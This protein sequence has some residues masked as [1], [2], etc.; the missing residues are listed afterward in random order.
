M[1]KASTKDAVA[2]M[3]PLGKL[4]PWEGNPRDNT[5]AV[6]AV[7]E[8]IARFGF[9]A[10]IVARKAD[11]EI[12]AGHTRWLAAQRLGMTE[13]PVRYL[14]LSLAEARALNLADN[15]VGEIAQWDEDKLLAA[16]AELHAEGA[17]LEGL[18]F[19]DFPQQV[20]RKI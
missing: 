20:D 8:S 10:P 7:A 14:D 9:A 13:V 15:R 19:E 3:V 11:G 6:D 17:S 4:V 1:A 2:A 16:A 12:I 18:G 5:S